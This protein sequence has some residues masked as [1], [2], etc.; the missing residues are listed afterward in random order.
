MVQIT[1]HFFIEAD[2]N[3]LVV[4]KKVTAKKGKRAGQTIDIIHGYYGTFEMALKGIQKE[5]IRMSISK[6]DMDLKEA[7]N[8]IKEINN[9]IMNITED[10]TNLLDK[11]KN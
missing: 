2:E 11:T 7:I 5:L 9:K 10:S 8:K 6:Y 3:C 4:I 1:K